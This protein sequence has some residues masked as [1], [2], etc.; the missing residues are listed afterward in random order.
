LPLQGNPAFGEQGVW[1]QQKCLLPRTA[2]TPLQMIG[3]TVPH[4]LRPVTAKGVAVNLQLRICRTTRLHSLLH[5]C[6]DVAIPAAS[7]T[8]TAATAPA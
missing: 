4:K 5:S 3:A 2:K 8:V 7:A 1:L 6:P